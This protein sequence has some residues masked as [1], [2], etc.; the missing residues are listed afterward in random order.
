MTTFTNLLESLEKLV[1]EILMWLVFIPKTLF[2][3]LRNPNWVPGYIEDEF[4]KK[5]GR[6]SEYVSPLIL[7][8]LL[9]LLPFW[10]FRDI[11]T[12]S[13]KMTEP[14]S[15]NVGD[16]VTIYAQPE[17]G[18]T[19]DAFI[20]SYAE[21]WSITNSNGDDVYKL[22]RYYKNLDS[23]NISE[24]TKKNSNLNNS[25]ATIDIQEID[26]SQQFP[27]KFSYS[28]KEAGI[29]T[30]DV[31]FFNS[32]G[33]ARQ[34]SQKIYVSSDSQTIQPVPKLFVINDFLALTL[35][36]TN[37]TISKISNRSASNILENRDIV[38]S[39]TLALFLFPLFLSL[40]SHL[41]QEGNVTRSGLQHH[42]YIHAM[43]LSPL[44]LS[45]MLFQIADAYQN[46]AINYSSIGWSKI[47]ALSITYLRLSRYLFN[48]VLTWFVVI[49]VRFVFRK[50]DTKALMTIIVSTIC[51]LVIFISSKTVQSI[52]I[53]GIPQ[54]LFG[55]YF[56]LI[57]LLP[58]WVLIYKIS[59]KLLQLVNAGYAKMSNKSKVV[60]H[61]EIKNLLIMEKRRVL[62]SAITLLLL[63]IVSTIPP[64]VYESQTTRGNVEFYQALIIFLFVV[65]CYLIAYLLGILLVSLILTLPKKIPKVLAVFFSFA[66]GI[67]I[68]WLPFNLSSNL[69]W[70]PDYFPYLN[71]FSPSLITGAILQDI[72]LTPLLIP[73]ILFVI[74]I[75]YMGWKLNNAILAKSSS[76]TKE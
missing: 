38:L 57:F 64:I 23:K 40:A 46:Q 18:T 50:I 36:P 71:V 25:N 48:I 42:F 16:V 13:V 58:I 47:P 8:S 72:F 29:Y 53:G 10:L 15:V 55:T 68:P 34:S 62:L 63:I 76:L 21:V 32:S 51:F 28:W 67:I 24:F 70:S 44:I 4:K 31:V 5:D 52:L 26:F 11:S 27:S 3:I 35:D 43:Y 75:V 74:V 61:Q 7:L 30:L 65:V 73:N 6:F 12:L 54:L 2:K 56:L 59:P 66:I 19:F 9:F 17:F 39:L 20:F 37:K 49:E 69:E 60:L 45:F 14:E 41:V 1:F 22:L 33:E